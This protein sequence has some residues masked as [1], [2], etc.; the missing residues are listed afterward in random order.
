MI[1]KKRLEEL[2]EQGATIYIADKQ[3][4]YPIPIFLRKNY[5]IDD[6]NVLNNRT[7]GIEFVK[8]LFETQKQAEWHLKMTRTR[9]E[10]LE[11]PTWEEFKDYNEN[12]SVSFIGEDWFVYELSKQT[13]NNK[14]YLILVVDGKIWKRWNFTEKDYIKACELCLKLFSGEEV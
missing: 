13:L 2:I 5:Y 1:E 8:N 4:N 14:L 9:T 3:T 6:D 12:I 7:F 11:L 10:T